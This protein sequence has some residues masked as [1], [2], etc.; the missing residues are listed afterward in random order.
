M[1]EFLFF[2]DA[3]YIILSLALLFSKNNKISRF[4]HK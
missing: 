3:F 4:S 2:E 1:V